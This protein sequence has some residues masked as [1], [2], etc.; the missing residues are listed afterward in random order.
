[1]CNRLK[2]QGELND[3]IRERI[4]SNLADIRADVQGRI[5]ESNDSLRE[6]YKANKH[7]V[8]KT[9]ERSVGKVREH[10]SELEDK[11]GRETSSKLRGLIHKAEGRVG[12]LTASVRQFGEKAIIKIKEIAKK[13][14][15]SVSQSFGISR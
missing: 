13:A 5:T 8:H 7:S 1:V 10:I 9:D 14:E 12:E 3:A 15:R 6:E 11:F 4:K 2:S